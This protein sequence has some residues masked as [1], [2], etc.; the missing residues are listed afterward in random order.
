MKNVGL[1]EAKTNLSALIA[2]LEATGDPIALTRH[3]V[4]VAELI[5]PSRKVSPKRGCLKSAD[6]HLADD[7]SKDSLG[8]EDFYR[9]LD[10]VPVSEVAEPSEGF[11]R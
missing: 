11:S 6:F 1:Y 4:V 9:S 8:F 7:F 5:P 2:E 3:G 10:V